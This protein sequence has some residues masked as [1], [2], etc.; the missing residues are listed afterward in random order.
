MKELCVACFLASV[1]DAYA[2]IARNI[3]GDLLKTVIVWVESPLNK[4]SSLHTTHI[5]MVRYY[6]LWRKALDNWITTLIQV[7]SPSNFSRGWHIPSRTDLCPWEMC[8]NRHSKIGAQKTPKSQGHPLL[9]HTKGSAQGISL[10]RWNVC[11]GKWTRICSEPNNF[12]LKITME[13]ILLASPT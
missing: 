8:G 2:Q 4:K 7:W 3:S 6:G 10:H 13:T 11:H 5:V 9:T 12:T 1:W